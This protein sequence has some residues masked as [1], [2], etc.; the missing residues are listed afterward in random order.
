MRRR[1]KPIRAIADNVEDGRKKEKN[2]EQEEDN[3]FFLLS[4]ISKR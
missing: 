2:E 3:G 1:R 4:W